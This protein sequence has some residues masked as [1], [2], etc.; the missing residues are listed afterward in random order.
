MGIACF[1]FYDFR[2]YWH[3]ECSAFFFL[4]FRKDFQSSQLQD[5]MLSWEFIYLMGLKEKKMQTKNL[6]ICKEIQRILS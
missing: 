4:V 1:N 2:S 5:L 3:K 6:I